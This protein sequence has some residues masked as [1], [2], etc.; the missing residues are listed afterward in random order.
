MELT[1]TGAVTRFHNHLE[2]SKSH[3]ERTITSYLS[4]LRAFVE[5]VGED[6]PVREVNRALLRRYLGGL[7]ENGLNPKTICRRIASF[8]AL[9]RYCMKEELIDRDPS[10]AVSSPKSGRDLPEFFSEAEIERLIN[11]I[12]PDTTKGVRDRAIIETFYST[13]A[14]VSE[15]AGLDV[16]SVRFGDSSV[17]LLGKGSKERNAILGEPAVAALKTWLEERPE[18][19]RPGETALFVNMR[20]GDQLTPRGIRYILKAYLRQIIPKA[21]PHSL[22]HSFATH[23]LNRGADLRTVQELLGHSSI[24]T[25][26]IYTHVSITQIKK[27]YEKAHPRA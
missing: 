6:P 15:I 25:T 5:W 23:L 18:I 16:E 14:R 9:F 27:Q 7:A 13:G 2:N 3:S 17:R 11:E 20:D 21:S 12:I 4:D 22:R 19:V 24:N 1:L 8:R 10:K 26:Q